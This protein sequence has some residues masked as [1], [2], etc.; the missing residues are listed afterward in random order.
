M[1]TRIAHTRRRNRSNSNR[2]VIGGILALLAALI[3]GAPVVTASAQATVSAAPQSTA[4]Q[5]SLHDRALAECAAGSGFARVAGQGSI[6]QA[7]HSWVMQLR[8]GHLL[9]VAPPDMAA[10]LAHP[11]SNPA[12][13][14]SSQA[15]GSGAAPASAI[16]SQCVSSLQ[17]PHIELFYAHFPGEPDN[18][19]SESSDIRQMF[20]DVDQ[21][22]MNYDSSNYFGLSFHLRAE[23]DSSFQPAVHDIALATPMS[24]SDFSTILSDMSSAGYCQQSQGGSCSAPGPVH[25]WIYTDGNP[26]ASLGYA[27]QSTVI[28]D[29]STGTGNAIN[30]SDAYSVNYGYCQSP[31]G[32]SGACD[33]P[34]DN[35]GAGSGAGIFAHENGHALGAVQLSAP[36]TTGAWHCFNGVAV[37]CYNDG[38]PQGAWYSTTYCGTAPNGTPLFDCGFN[39]YFNPRPSPGSYLATHWD[40]ASSYDQWAVSQPSASATGLR[41]PTPYPVQGQPLTLTAAVGPVSAPNPG[42]ATGTVTFND[43]TTVLGSAPVGGSGTASLTT[44]SLAAGTHQLSAAYSGDS[45]YTASS[46]PGTTV[47][48]YPALPG[49]R[50]VPVTPFRVLDTRSASCVQCAPGG[51]P[52]SPAFTRVVQVIGNPS[53]NGTV[54]SNALAVV[55]NLTGTQGTAAT[56]LQLGPADSTDLAAT[57]T[58]NIE[59]ASDQGNLIIAPL[60]PGGQLWLFNSAGYIHAVVDIEGYFVPQSSPV[61]GGTA[62]TFH[63]IVPVRS[64]DTR[65]NGGTACAG[66]TANPLGPGQWRA[67]TLWS[68]AANGVPGDGTAAAAA[69][70]LTATQGTLGTYLTA[71]APDPSTHACGAPPS[72]ASLNVPAGTDRP[73]R[74]IV[75]IDPTNGEVCIYNSVGTVDFVI[76]VNGWFGTGGEATEGTLYYSGPLQR[77]CDTRSSQPANQCTGRTLGSGSTLQD[78]A[79][80]GATSGSPA[81]AAAVSLN[82]AGT[83]ATLGTYVTAYPDTASRPLTSDINVAAQVNFSDQAIVAL[84]RDGGVD[85]FNSLGSIDVVI[86]VEGWFA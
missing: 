25:Y 59:A 67:V 39:D 63:P 85:L 42:A 5:T 9:E 1:R 36:D 68:G 80:S 3:A 11:V 51:A 17:Q 34:I 31:I 64:C 8:D 21:N 66:A 76:D 83:N 70:N 75:P 35:Q 50:Y 16:P 40:I 74:V 77:V 15:T 23:C 71:Y 44:S 60:G 69:F 82:V 41:L 24:Q 22:Y 48:V 43:G 2:P 61:P 37:M 54:P 78:V 12:T 84:G 13:T 46:S 7:D 58:L 28:G 32:G 18:Y 56:F 14:L 6:C 62:G 47:I 72:T 19:G 57:S 38:G 55:A 30:S 73:H 79:F 33:P 27:G 10:T 53:G 65:A 20:Y 81:A 52:L 29:D 49:A 4:R 45:N 86:D 26:V